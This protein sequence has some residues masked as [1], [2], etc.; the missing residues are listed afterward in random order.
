MDPTC[1]SLLYLFPNLS[2]THSLSL[3]SPTQVTAEAVVRRGGSGG[4][5]GRRKGR[6]QASYFFQIYI[7]SH[8]P[9]A[10]INK[11]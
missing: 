10:S 1:Q 8:A 11:Q 7:V 9:K 5:A 4:E 3:F 6:A 2:H